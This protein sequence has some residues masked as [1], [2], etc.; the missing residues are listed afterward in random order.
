MSYLQ[1]HFSKIAPNEWKYEFIGGA[2]GGGVG[3]SQYW[4]WGIQGVWEYVKFQALG[5]LGLRGW[6]WF[7]NQVYT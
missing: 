2:S 4:H 5:L 1:L 6:W 3:M 7:D